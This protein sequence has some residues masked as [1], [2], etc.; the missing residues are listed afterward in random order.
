MHRLELLTVTCIIK[1]LAP[2]EDAVLSALKAAEKAEQ[3][4]KVDH[5]LLDKVRACSANPDM[6]ADFFLWML[7]PIPTWRLSAEGCFHPYLEPTYLRMLDE[8]PLPESHPCKEITLGKPTDPGS[9]VKIGECFSMCLLQLGVTQ[10]LQCWCVSLVVLLLASAALHVCVHVHADIWGKDA[11][12]TLG[13]Q[14]TLNNEPADT[15]QMQA[16]PLSAC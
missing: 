5:P 13:C 15:T 7:S 12:L 8:F 9:F 3:P 6:A 10:Y 11:M 4:R 16:M 2:Q 14:E 1:F